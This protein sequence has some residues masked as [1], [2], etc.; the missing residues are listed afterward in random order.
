MFLNLPHQ[1]KKTSKT[2]NQNFIL[3]NLEKLTCPKSEDMCDPQIAGHSEMTG[4]L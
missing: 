2:K 3:N 1:K 4:G